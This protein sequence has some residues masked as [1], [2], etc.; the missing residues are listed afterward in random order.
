MTTPDLRLVPKSPEKTAAWLPVAM[1]AYR[2]ARQ[3][4]GEN[5]EQAAEASRM[6]ESQFFPEGRLIDGHFLFTVEA[7]GEDAGWL[8]LG[9]MKDV[10]TWYVWDV[11]LHEAFRGRGIG[12]ATMALAEE[13]A[14]SQGATMMQLNVFAYN[15][16]AI[17]LYGSMGYTVT[18]MHMQKPLERHGSGTG[19]PHG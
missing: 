19:T 16:P 13:F 3:R 18:S 4:A 6:S 12:R 8:W 1:T 5:A 7:D 17:G 10:S 15:E 2:Q 11:A 9:P 14:R